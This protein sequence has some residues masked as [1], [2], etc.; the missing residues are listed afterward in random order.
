[1]GLGVAA[2]ADGVGGWALDGIDAG[3]FSRC[4]ASAECM[5]LRLMRTRRADQHH[6]L[7]VYTVN[8]LLAERQTQAIG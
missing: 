8:L 1:M 3:E 7:A 2:V 5:L 4:R 6:M